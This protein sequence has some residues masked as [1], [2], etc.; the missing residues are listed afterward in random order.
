MDCH[1]SKTKE[2]ALQNTIKVDIHIYFIPRYYVKFV[3][4]RIQQWM[5]LPNSTLRNLL[6]K[7][8]ILNENSDFTLITYLPEL[9]DAV[10]THIAVFR[11][12]E[13]T[14]HANRSKISQ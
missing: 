2:Y 6:I 9:G 13:C 10:V 3:H 12:T 14:L 1:L 5:I 8:I 7:T 11:N 4:L